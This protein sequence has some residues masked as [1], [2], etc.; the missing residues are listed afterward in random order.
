MTYSSDFIDRYTTISSL[1]NLCYC[2]EAQFIIYIEHED[3]IHRGHDLLDGNVLIAQ[4]IDSL[5]TCRCS[6]EVRRI[7]HTL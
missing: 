1:E 6:K 3:T 7:L 2:L 5:V 4:T